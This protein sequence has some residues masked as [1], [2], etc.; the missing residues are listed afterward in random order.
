MADY[1]VTCN[2]YHPYA[3]TDMTGPQSVVMVEKRFKAGK[4]D[5][6]EYEWQ[7]NPPGPEG[8]GPFVCYLSSEEA[9]PI[10]G[11]I[12]YVSGGKIGVYAEPV[13]KKTILKEKGIWETKELLEKMPQLLSDE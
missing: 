10:N 1:H 7:Q 12:F 3:R 4:I 11:K 2:A 8:I 6:E 13:R 9:A 5:R